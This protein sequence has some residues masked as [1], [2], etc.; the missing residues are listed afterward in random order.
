MLTSKEDENKGE[1][2]DGSQRSQS[3]QRTELSKDH[4]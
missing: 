3:S 2:H 1:V 4:V